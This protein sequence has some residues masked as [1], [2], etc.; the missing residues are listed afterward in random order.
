MQTLTILEILYTVLIVFSTIIGT[1]TT[2]VLL[3]ILKI[4]WPLEELVNIY[5]KFKYIFSNYLNIIEVLK[6][7]FFKN[8]N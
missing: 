7:R 1:L 8:K 2:I 3:K 6:Q 4:L 5:S